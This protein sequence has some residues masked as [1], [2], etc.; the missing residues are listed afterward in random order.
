[1]LFSHLD[2][3][4]FL[5]PTTKTVLTDLNLELEEG[6]TVQEALL[7]TLESAL[8]KKGLMKPKSLAQIKKQIG[9]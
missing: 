3:K 2:A 1:L 8:I 7:M 4:I 9:V 5:M 6:L